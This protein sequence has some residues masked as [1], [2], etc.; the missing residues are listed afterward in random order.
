[1]GVPIRQLIVLYGE[2]NS[3]D[4]VGCGRCI[5]ACPQHALQFVDVRDSLKH[6]AAHVPT[7]NKKP[8]IQ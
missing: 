6:L 5:Q 2:I 4:C 3:P 7:F 1:M 8:S